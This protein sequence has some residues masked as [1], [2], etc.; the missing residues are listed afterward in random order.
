MGKPLYTLRKKGRFS[1]ANIVGA[2][3]WMGCSIRRVHVPQ[4]KHDVEGRKD[5][6]LPGRRR[7]GSRGRRKGKARVGKTRRR[8]L[9]AARNP[10]KGIGAK[11]SPVTLGLPVENKLPEIGRAGKIRAR[12]I[13]WLEE[14]FAFVG[15]TDRYL[16]FSVRRKPPGV[17]FEM[18]SVRKIRFSR[19]VKALTTKKVPR[20]PGISIDEWVRK[21]LDLKYGTWSDVSSDLVDGEHSLGYHIVSPPVEVK[22]RLYSSSTSICRLCGG[23]GHLA[24]DCSGKKPTS[25]PTRGS[26]R[27]GERKH[28]GIPSHLRF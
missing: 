27:G 1:T 20:P 16:R 5:P 22:R 26:Y 17:G 19:L 11:A 15:E 14:R 8:L 12:R 2:I 23:L 13:A 7:R 4:M 25:P 9:R 24:K 21:F 18:R 28:R 6:S 3:M 10:A